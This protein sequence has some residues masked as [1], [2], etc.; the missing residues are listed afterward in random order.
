[1][2]A[3]DAYETPRLPTVTRTQPP[4][5]FPA[6]DPAG[7]FSSTFRYDTVRIRPIQPGRRDEVESRIVAFQRDEM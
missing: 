6:P 3:L 4:H 7:D 2:K 1:M 5:S